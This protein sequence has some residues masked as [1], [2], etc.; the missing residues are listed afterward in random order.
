M[1]MFVNLP[2]YEDD[3]LQ[4][5]NMNDLSLEKLARLP[6]RLSEGHS[7]IHLL[8]GLSLGPIRRKSLEL[9]YCRIYNLRSVKALHKSS[10]LNLRGKLCGLLSNI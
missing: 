7:A 10:V 3:I 1:K 2:L 9:N 8:L 6:E 4:C 5:R